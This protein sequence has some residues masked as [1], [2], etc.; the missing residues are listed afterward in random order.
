TGSPD[1]VVGVVDSGVDV[2]HPDLTG[3]QWTNPG[4]TGTD[5]QGRNK[6]TNGV[7]DDGDGLV[8]D[9]HGWDFACASEVPPTCTSAKGDNTPAD[10]NGHGTH[11]AGIVGARANDGVGVTGVAPNT[12]ILPVR[13][14]D[15]TGS[16]TDA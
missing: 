2:T 15:A 8:D 1:V 7:D 12:A 11:V 9:V 3:A 10:L 14:L 5:A 4:E 6:A 13:V 16:G